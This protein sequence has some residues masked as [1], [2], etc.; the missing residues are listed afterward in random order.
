MSSSVKPPWLLALYEQ[1]GMKLTQN[2]VYDVSQRGL[3]SASANA[4]VPPVEL[5]LLCTWN[6]QSQLSLTQIHSRLVHCGR[7]DLIIPSGKSVANNIGC[8]VGCRSRVRARAPIL[9]VGGL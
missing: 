2:Q 6:A 7:R 5:T 4:A 8:Y 1:K 9:G 3:E